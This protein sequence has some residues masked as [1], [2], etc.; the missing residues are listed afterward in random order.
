MKMQMYFVDNETRKIVEI[1]A[2]REFPPENTTEHNAL[3]D[4]WVQ[5]VVQTY[6]EKN[7][8]DPDTQ[9]QFCNDRSEEF[10]QQWKDDTPCNHDVT[11]LDVAIV[12]IDKELDTRGVKISGQCSLCGASVQFPGVHS[13]NLQEEVTIAMEFAS[14]TELVTH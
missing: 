4:R 7:K 2:Q 5:A 6:T 9:L 12:T 11:H 3:V 1:I 14:P 8:L 10:N 13:Q